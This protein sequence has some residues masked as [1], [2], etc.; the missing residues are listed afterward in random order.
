[1]HPLNPLESAGRVAGA[2]ALVAGEAAAA[3]HSEFDQGAALGA[4]LRFFGLC[5]P[6]GHILAADAPLSVWID[7]EPFEWNRFAADFAD[8]GLLPVAVV[9]IF[10]EVFLDNEKPRLVALVTRETREVGGQQLAN[11]LR[12][13]MGGPPQHSQL[14]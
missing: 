14:A 6:V 4:E 3:A 9:V 12:R 5:A 2:E 10:L 7:F 11:H 13:G 1:M 8:H